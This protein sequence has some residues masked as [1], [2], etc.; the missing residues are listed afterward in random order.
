MD[1]RRASGLTQEALSGLVD[2]PQ[3]YL[4]KIETYQR[5]LDAL[6]LFDLIRALEISPSQFANKAAAA[7]VPR[8]GAR[9]SKRT[10]G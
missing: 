9:R 1:A 10:D 2:R 6:E 8:P 7:V 3:S 4:G 5:R